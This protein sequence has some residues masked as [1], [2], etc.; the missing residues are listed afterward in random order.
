MKDFIEERK[1]GL[2]F[3]LLLKN[4]FIWKMV[5]GAGPYFKESNG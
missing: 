3:W 5:G 2:G 4:I 1:R